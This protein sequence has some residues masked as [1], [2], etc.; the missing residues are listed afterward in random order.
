MM[1]TGFCLVVARALTSVGY[2]AVQV[3]TWSEALKTFEREKID[4]LFCDLQPPDVSRRELLEGLR[5]LSDNLRVI[6][7]SS[8]ELTN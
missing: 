3:S 5:W 1:T 6:V 4:V 8:E 7:T 2:R